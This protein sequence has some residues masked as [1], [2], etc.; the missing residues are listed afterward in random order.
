MEALSSTLTEGGTHGQEGIGATSSEDGVLVVMTCLTVS[1][2][3]DDTNTSLKHKSS[4]PEVRLH[5]ASFKR[6]RMMTNRKRKWGNAG[7]RATN[8][9]QQRGGEDGGIQKDRVK[10]ERRKKDRTQRQE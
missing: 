3:C 10:E 7:Q 1:F 2:K 5:P 6:G 4:V 9:D 8:Q